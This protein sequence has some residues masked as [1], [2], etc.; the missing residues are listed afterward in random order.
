MNQVLNTLLKE[1]VQKVFNEAGIAC[2][3][4]KPSLFFP[5]NPDI[6]CT[7]GITG[8]HHGFL[9]LTLTGEEAKHLVKLFAN[10]FSVPVEESPD[11]S[12]FDRNTLGE[13]MNQISGNWCTLLSNHHIDCNITPPT[14]IKGKGVSANTSGLEKYKPFRVKGL[15]GTAQFQLTMKN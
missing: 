13:I 15:F 10:A 5:V 4:K 3:I 11:F 2:S 6:L 9:N 7:I 14:I 12:A 8:E 1:T